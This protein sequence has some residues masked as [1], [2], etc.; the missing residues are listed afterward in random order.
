MPPNR[1]RSHQLETE[2]Q[3]AFRALI[4]PLWVFR[5]QTP[6]YGIDGEVEIFESS[7]N[8]TGQKFLVQLKGTDNNDNS[9][10]IPLKR[11]TAEYFA[12]QKLP[13]LVVLFQAQTKKVFGRWFHSFDSYGHKPDSETLSFCFAVSDELD[14]GDLEVLS[15]DVAAFSAAF[16]PLL[17]HRSPKPAR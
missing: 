6:D 5:P 1:P 15:N 4:E 8:T 17:L 12:S 3:A 16:S 9:P 10:A 2:S 7:G 14:K 13:V 11:T